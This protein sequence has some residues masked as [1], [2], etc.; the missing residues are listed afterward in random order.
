[1]NRREGDNS[2]I[3]TA[4]REQLIA[5]L[6][7]RRLSTDGS[8]SVLALQLLRR[9]RAAFT[10]E[11]AEGAESR[12]MSDS[13]HLVLPEGEG[14]RP[15]SPYEVARGPIGHVHARPS[16][17]SGGHYSQD[18][19]GGSAGNAYNIMR[20]WNLKFSGTRGEDAETF[21][22]RIEEGRELIPVEDADILRCL[23]FFLS[24]IAL[25]WFR[26]KK[27]R[28]TTWAAFKAAWRVRFGDLDF[29]FAL[30]DEIMHRTQGERES[31]VDYLTCL[32]SLFDRLTPSWSEA[33]K[34]GYA[35]RHMLPRLQ[36]M[37]PREAVTDLDAL[38]PDSQACRNRF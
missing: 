2:W 29:Q 11:S 17:E 24:G 30:R 22:I 13:D 20:K 14:D 32:G 19:G 1:M 10:G 36:A 15:D 18:L 23:P 12:E 31:V 33:E 28:L 4:D 8:D 26:G 25:H 34:I 7:R 6:E 3:F 16:R 5:E 37:V 27:A 21:L 38:D 35:H 9:G